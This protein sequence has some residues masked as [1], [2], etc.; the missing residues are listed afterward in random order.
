MMGWD[1]YRRRYGGNSPNIR[2]AVRSPL[3]PRTAGQSP[4]NNPFPGGVYDPA[5]IQNLQQAISPLRNPRNHGPYGAAVARRPAPDLNLLAALRLEPR[6]ARVSAPT[7]CNDLYC[8]APHGI[9]QRHQQSH[10]YDHSHRHCPDPLPLRRRKDHCDICA[11]E[12]QCLQCVPNP[13]LQCCGGS[14]PK[15]DYAFETKDV[16]VRG[17]TYAIRKSYLSE[18]GKFEETLVKYMEKASED[19]VPDRIVGFLVSFINEEKIHAENLHDLITLN[20]LASNVCAKSVVEYSMAEIKRWDIDRDLPMHA[21]IDIAVT[22]T[23][24]SKVELALKEWLIKYLKYNDRWYQMTNHPM[25]L[26]VMHSR[27]EVDTKLA[28][29]MGY[30][31]SSDEQGF[32]IL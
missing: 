26:G 4:L 13:C 30:K 3:F 9:G 5:R 1:P 20:I 19:A 15:K 2:P 10:G 8:N 29:L 25:Y 24:S 32:R 22:I 23:L 14:D 6:L 7:L 11:A 21:L 12:A 27:P 17:K 18:V 16:V 31:N 28:I